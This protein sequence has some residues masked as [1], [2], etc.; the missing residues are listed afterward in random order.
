MNRES[1]KFQQWEKSIDEGTG[2]KEMTNTYRD[3]ARFYAKAL[4]IQ[5]AELEAVGFPEGVSPDMAFQLAEKLSVSILIENYKKQAKGNSGLDMAELTDELPDIQW[6]YGDGSNGTARPKKTIED[7]RAV[8]DTN[9]AE[10]GVVELDGG[11]RLN[12]GKILIKKLR[13]KEL[14]DS[15]VQELRA[16]L[17]VPTDQYMDWAS[18]ANEIECASP[19][20][21]AEWMK[22]RGMI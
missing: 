17:S 19:E 13:D 4:K 1:H 11:L 18:M 12:P 8:Q 9:H 14:D 5:Y 3:L 22:D 21:L 16:I 20:M 15:L 7:P 2:G 6:L 10:G